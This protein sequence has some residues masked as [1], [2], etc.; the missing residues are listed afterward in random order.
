MEIWVFL[1]LGTASLAGSGLI[2]LAMQRGRHKQQAYEAF[3]TAQGWR[4]ETDLAGRS[5][6][7]RF[8][9]P[10]DD[11][12]LDVVFVG[13]GASGGST[14]RRVNWQSPQGALSSGEAVLGLPLPEKAVAVLH[15]GGL[16]AQQVLKGA[17]KATIQ[18]LGQAKFNLVLDETSAGDP[19]GV[20]MASD[21]RFDAM[22]RVK[23]SPELAQFRKD[24]NPAEVPIILRDAEGLTLRRSGAVREL[25]ELLAIVELGKALRARVT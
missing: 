25:D 3:A 10:D 12:T 1:I 6:T 4:L 21:G 22:D 7:Q 2:Y 19:G 18:A 14:R 23:Q 8:R 20:V 9:D 11:W 24:R 15:G 13:A 16:I 17:L 5:S